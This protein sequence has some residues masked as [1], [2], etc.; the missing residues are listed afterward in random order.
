MELR[1]FIHKHPLIFNEEPNKDHGGL[2]CDGCEEQIWGPNYSCKECSWFILHKSCA[3][4]PPSWTTRCTPNISFISTMRIP[5]R[6][7]SNATVAIQRF[8]G[9]SFTIVLTVILALKV[10]VLL[11]R[12]PSKLKFMPTH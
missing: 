8:Y 1:H 3:E 12:S 10:N 11:Y 2:L 6:G 7:K 4:L 5:G 9:A